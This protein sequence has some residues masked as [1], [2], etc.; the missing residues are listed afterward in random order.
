MYLYYFNA[1]SVSAFEN[2]YETQ[3]LK[4]ARSTRDKTGDAGASCPPHPRSSALDP[5]CFLVGDVDE[6]PDIG[7]GNPVFAPQEPSDC[8]EPAPLPALGFQ[9]V[10]HIV[11]PTP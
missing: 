4:E 9:A 11:V 3:G 10:F 8:M 1:D 6:H 2:E 5:S 7:K